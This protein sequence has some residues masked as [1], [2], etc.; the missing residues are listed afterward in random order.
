MLKGLNYQRRKET[1]IEPALKKL[2]GAHGISKFDV[3]GLTQ[4]Y[5]AVSLAAHQAT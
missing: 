4:N 5:K 1:K 2:H 3:F